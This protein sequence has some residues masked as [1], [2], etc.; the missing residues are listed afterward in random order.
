MEPVPSRTV[1]VFADMFPHFYYDSLFWLVVFLVVFYTTKAIL[2]TIF[3]HI[4]RNISSKEDRVDYYNYYLSLSHHL[5]VV[6]LA[7]YRLLTINGAASIS[8]CMLSGGEGY[9]EHTKAFFHCE[10]SAYMTGYLLADSLTYAL[11]MALKGNYMYLGHHAMALGVSALVPILTAEVAPLCS[12]I[13]LLE[14]SSIFFAISF[15][16]K[17]S[18]FADHPIILFLEIAFGVSFFFSRIVNLSALVPEVYF[19]LV[20]DAAST[21]EEITLGWFILGLF[22]PLWALQ[23]FWFSKIVAGARSLL[24]AKES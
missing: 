15:L 22:V 10:S 4:I 9:S 11:P 7:C 2:D 12:R 16:L 5:V 1:P 24:K 20:A 19:G 6:P 8:T 13:M 17:Q 21:A 18:G 3:P 23:M 14:T